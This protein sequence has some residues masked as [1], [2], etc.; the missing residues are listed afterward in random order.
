MGGFESFR[1]L[2]EAGKLFGGEADPTLS[3]Q[4]QQ[5][6]QQQMNGAVKQQT[7]NYNHSQNNQNGERMAHRPRQLL[8]KMEMDWGVSMG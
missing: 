7:Q 8:V 1:G 4:Q 5:Q 2:V 3:K 6:Q